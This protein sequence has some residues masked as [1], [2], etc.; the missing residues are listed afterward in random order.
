MIRRWRSL[1]A[2]GQYV[3]GWQLRSSGRIKQNNSDMIYIKP[4]FNL[5]NVNNVLNLCADGGDADLQYRRN[6]RVTQRTI[7][8]FTAIG[9]KHT[10]SRSASKPPD[11]F[12]ELEIDAEW[13]CDDIKGL[14]KPPLSL[15]TRFITLQIRN[16]LC[17][18]LCLE[19]P[20]WAAYSESNKQAHQCADPA[21]P[22]KSWKGET[23]L[24]DL[25]GPQFDQRAP[26]TDEK[27]SHLPKL[28]LCIVMFY[29]YADVIAFLGERLAKECIEHLLT[30][31]CLRV[32][33]KGWAH[34]SQVISE[35]TGSGKII[36]RQLS[37]TIKDLFGL[38][39]ESLIS[40][41]NAY[42]IPML[43][44]HLMKEYKLTMHVAYSNPELRPKMIEYA[45]GDLVLSDI[46]EA[47]V[48]HYRELCDINKVTPI[49]FPPTTKGAFVAHIFELVLNSTIKLPQDFYKIFDIPE[50][51][52]PSISHLLKIYGCKALAKSENSLTKQFLAIVHGG[53][54]KN[55]CPLIIR[56]CGL[57]IS[58]DIVSCYG[59][60]LQYLYMPIGHPALFYYP[61]HHPSE[62]PTLR[63]FIKRYSHEMV[64]GCWYL[65][66]D[67]CGE[68]LTFSQNLLY[69]KVYKNDKPEIL[70]TAKLGESFSEDLAHVK[71]DFMLIENEVRN[72][73]LTHYSLSILEHCASNLEW[74]D[75]LDKLRVK[76]GLIYPSS[77]CHEYTGPDSID[78]WLSD[79]RHRGSHISTFE[80]LN[81]HG[82]KDSRVGPW[83]KYPLSSFITPL[84]DRRRS[85]K[86][87]MKQHPVDSDDWN[88]LNASQKSLKK[89]VNTLYGIL[90]SI[91]FPISSPCV[92]N[93]V[94]DRARTA[95]WLMSV[96]SAGLTSITDG[97][98][99][100][101]NEVRFWKEHAPSLETAAHLH[102]PYRIKKRTR[103]KHWTAPLGSDGDTSI[104]WDV[105][106]NGNITGPGQEKPVDVATA[107]KHIESLYDAHFRK[108]FTFSGKPLPTWCDP[109][110]FECKVLGRNIALHGSANYA[111]GLLDDRPAIIKARGHRMNTEHYDPTTGVLLEPPMLTMML[112]RL[113]G[114]P[115]K[116][117][118]SSVNYKPASLND[119]RNRRQ[120]REKGGL[121]GYS[122]AKR[123][124][125]RLI[126]A[127]EF[128]YPT[129][130]SRSSWTLYGA[131][132]NRRYGLG[133]E[134][135]YIKD[136]A[137]PHMTVEQIE[138]AKADIQRR[139]YSEDTPSSTRVAR[140]IRPL[141]EAEAQD[142]SAD[143]SD[144]GSEDL[145]DSQPSEDYYSEIY[146]S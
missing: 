146:S 45:L 128:N 5:K 111:I 22:L 91:Y 74:N 71:G 144:D 32:A 3:E 56:K 137:Q 136:A 49:D 65:V 75:L 6:L 125:V 94:T 139:I 78:A 60:A 64:P 117:R 141:D 120:F 33:G 29:S 50:S 104:R 16:P 79:V 77:L 103:Q 48:K 62:W 122:I 113:R 84:L 31:K 76:S 138:S 43:V 9:K 4:F 39:Y 95:C 135:T 70:E 105:D 14:G 35:K 127:T 42:N 55:E 41:A 90:A 108:Y 83:L 99:S 87:E 67:T 25:L 27:L 58:M 23:P 44:K 114:E 124:S 26:H 123:T 17:G 73:I 126:T 15:P 98:E 21:S 132:L 121:P 47:Y 110:K 92:A 89:V 101:L 66:I 143:E 93:N 30:G 134:A 68:F 38:E 54:V 142:D 2:P 109:I 63:E 131:Y 85:L 88:R 115:M 52:V 19:H 119:Y 130:E 97:C 57:V 37:V 82:V 107:I 81:M 7:L 13:W 145:S 80:D 20:M 24:P 1:A 40:T 112:N 10:K 36:E 106:S 129:I 51:K 96:A 59:Q 100:M 116:Y 34:L 53:R 86:A 46:I 140:S 11:L 18:K 133:L 102:L 8:Y 69:S 118:Q 61:H 28:R 72:G 12:Y